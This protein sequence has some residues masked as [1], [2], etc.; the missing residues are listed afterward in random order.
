MTFYTPTLKIETFK[1]FLEGPQTDNINIYGAVAIGEIKTV[2][3][4]P[5]STAEFKSIYDALF[6]KHIL[7][8]PMKKSEP[9]RESLSVLKPEIVGLSLGGI[10]SFGIGIFA[11]ATHNTGL[12]TVMAGPFLA[13]ILGSTLLLTGLRRKKQ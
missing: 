9:M 12:A 7:Q 3:Y 6:A 2:E 1:S 4:S 8:Q 10:V 5:S 11:L 13:S